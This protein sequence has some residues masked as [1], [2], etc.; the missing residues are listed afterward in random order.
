MEPGMT[1]MFY[2][3][4]VLVGLFTVLLVGLSVYQALQEKGKKA[5]KLE[6][7]ESV[8]EIR[9]VNKLATPRYA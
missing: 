4:L 7:I 5:K 6:K 2:I 3:D 1:I 8:K 9:H